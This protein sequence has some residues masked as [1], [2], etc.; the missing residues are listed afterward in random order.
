MILLGSKYTC[1]IFCKGAGWTVG[2]IEIQNHLAAFQG[3]GIKVPAGRIRLF[4][5][6]EV[7]KFDEQFVIFYFRGIELIGFAIEFERDIPIHAVFHGLA[8][9]IGLFRYFWLG[10]TCVAG[11]KAK[12]FVD[13]E[14]L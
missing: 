8:K 3:R 6:G 11:M 7:L 12:L 10:I 13:R 14:P 9:R 4:A 1:G 5:A 2:V